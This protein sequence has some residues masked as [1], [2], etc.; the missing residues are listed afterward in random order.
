[1]VWYINRVLA[2][3]LALALPEPAAAQRVK[4]GVLTCDVSAGIGFIIGSHKSVSC[5]FVPEG[6]GRREDYDGDI[7]KWGL[8]IGVTQAGV[9]IWA[10]FANTIAG[11]GFFAGD[12][13]GATGEVTIAAGLGAN[14][15]I[16]GSNRS[17]ALQPLSVSG[18]LG[19][20][21]AVGVAALHLGL[22][23]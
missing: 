13:Y 21:L 20:N 8:D 12:Y 1:M 6:S 22:P 18:Q 10:V 9:M 14:V 7:T 23:R 5:S 3:I 4:L 19:L 11:P 16:G 2:L 15:L 17:V